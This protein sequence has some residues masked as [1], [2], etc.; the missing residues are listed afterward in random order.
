MNSLINLKEKIALV[1]GANQGI[2]FELCRQLAYDGCK[3]ILTSRDIKQGEEATKKLQKENLDII[4]HQLDV[5]DINSIEVIYNY[6]VER[7]G[8]L[9][10]LINNAGIYIDSDQISNVSPE[11]IQQTLET[12]AIGSLRMCQQ[13][14]PLMKKNNF[15]RIV[16]VSSGMGVIGTMRSDSPAYRI[17]KTVL[18]AIS[19]MLSCEN[20]NENILINS[21]CPGP[22]KTRMSNGAKTPSEVSPYIIDICR[23]PNGGYS[24]YFFRECEII[25]W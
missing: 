10:V 23:L 16:N 18:N 13:F 14:L 2:G 1:T 7:F 17:S 24:G 3:V 11:T 12:N 9:D 5:T 6:I 8:I 19:K 15:G 22:V 20:P 4:Y 21:V 25:D